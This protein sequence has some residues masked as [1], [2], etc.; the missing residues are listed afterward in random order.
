MLVYINYIWR[1][2]TFDFGRG[3]GHNELEHFSS[4][5]KSTSSKLNFGVQ[6]IMRVSNST[7]LICFLITLNFVFYVIGLFLTGTAVTPKMEGQ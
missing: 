3:G 4:S 2:G 5:K 6:I 7:I 1:F